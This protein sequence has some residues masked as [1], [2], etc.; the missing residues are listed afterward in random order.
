MLQT[1][2][3][4]P[5]AACLAAL[6]ASAST[7]GSAQRPQS[8]PITIT[9]VGQSMIRSD[10]RATA[11]AA[12]PV[13][14]GLLKGDVVF[15]NLEAAVAEKGETVREGRGFLTPPEALDALTTLGFN[16]LSFSGNHAFDLKVTGIQNTIREAD[17]RK[18][19][20]AGTG[21]NLAEAGAPGYLHTPK[22]TIALIASTSGLITTRGSTTAHHP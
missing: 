10:I 11:P 7:M 12:V 5:R 18:V 9:L 19:V 22:G 2:P 8:A 13:I 16:L 15:T 6:F 21:N 20:H 14:Q 17:R 1:S 4:L 3:F